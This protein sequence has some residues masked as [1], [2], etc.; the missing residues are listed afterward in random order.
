MRSR[1]RDKIDKE[2][3]EEKKA[4]SSAEMK[5]TGPETSKRGVVNSNC[6]YVKVRKEPS[7]EAEVLELLKKGAEVTILGKEKGFYKVS[8]RMT[9]VAYIA[10][11]FIK[12]V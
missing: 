5:T 11:D 9:P 3:K 6:V 8:T 7:F 10:L 1:E 12:E 4:R 2:I